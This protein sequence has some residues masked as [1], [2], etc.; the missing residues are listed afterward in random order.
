MVSGGEGVDPVTWVTLLT[1]WVALPL[2][3][4]GLFRPVWTRALPGFKSTNRENLQRTRKQNHR[5][6]EID[7]QPR[8]ID[9][10]G[11]EWG[12]RSRGI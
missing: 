2:G 4:G 10:G 12:G 6:G 9:N 3:F 1:G 5:H 8:H 11:N 7:N